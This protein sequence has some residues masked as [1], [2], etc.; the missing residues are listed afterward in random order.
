M[1]P[2]FPPRWL[3]WL[4]WLALLLAAPAGAAFTDN[5]NGTVTDTV[6]GLM[7][8][9]CA[10]G[11]TFNA[12]ATGG[13]CAGGGTVGNNWGATTQTWPASL[14]LANTAN[15]ASHRG[16]TGWRLPNR[17][18][19]ESLVDITKATAP[20]I[21]GTAFPNTP[22]SAFFWSS[23]VYAP[24]PAYAWFVPFFN[25]GTDGFQSNPYHVRLVRS[26]QSFGA[27]DALACGPGVPLTTGAGALWQMLALP[28]V[29]SAAAP[30]P[31]AVFGTGTLSNLA[32]A[33]YGVANPG[34]GTGWVIHRRDVGEPPAYVQL[35]TG[36][37][38]A[39][40]AGFWIKS[41]QAPTDGK[42]VLSGTLTPTDATQAQGCAS[43]N[44]CKAITV[45][46]P[47]AA[48][49]RY[50]LVGNPFPYAI[51]W[52]KVRIRV[53]G[54][55]G[56]IYTPSQAAGIGV[57]AA[58][59]SVLSNEVNIW[60][61]TTYDTI[62]D[63]LPASFENLRY[64]QSF[65]VNVLPGAFGQTIELLIPVEVSTKTS[66]AGPAATE[67]LA[68]PHRPWYLGWL[69]WVVP[70]AAAQPA[71]RP[72]P[73]V[74][75][76]AHPQALA[77]PEDWYVRLKVDNRV[78]GWQDHGLLLGQLADAKPGYD[79]HDQSKMAPFAKPYLM[80]AFPQP[81]WGQHQ[82]EYAT[83]FRPT[84][85]RPPQDWSFEVRAE[86]VGSKVFLSWE[87][88][89]RILKRSR[90]VDLQTGKT[91]KPA[92][93]RWARKGYP[94]TLKRPVTRFTWRYLGP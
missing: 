48:T 9:Q 70:P 34:S 27:F 63:V 60:N 46:T 88:E 73:A 93:S 83:D 84:Q 6:T 47:S 71:P 1:I 38:L 22:T 36:D 53:G 10:W 3:P 14:A 2:R 74:S 12:S 56:S 19:L 90:L 65:W 5:G 59:P 45:T 61:G 4:P 64:F 80:L 82:G 75:G 49:N 28:C 11:Q 30:N 18:E 58:S 20:A 33:D 86:P 50:N 17:T 7:W 42:L 41:Y 55:G 79:P 81:G 13:K 54:P 69:D 37:T 26:G 21:D 32:T 66:Q 23:T 31:P 52:S 25:G 92:A 76:H 57:G 62:S 67:S 94:V 8:D 72:A 39:V 40:G 78:T 89:R 24:S 16:Y 29:P 51:D 44:G 77:N 15:A 91:L 85:D 87:G 68:A 43:A 35:G